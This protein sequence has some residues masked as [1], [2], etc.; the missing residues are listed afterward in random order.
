MKKIL[1]LFSFLFLVSLS[2]Q[3]QVRKSSKVSSFILKGEVREATS[4]NPVYKVNVEVNGGNYTT[5]NRAGEFS[6]SVSIGDELIIKSDNF[7]TVFYT[8]KD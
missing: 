7:K 4:N 6:I 2:T 5:T 1:L 8:I 3:A